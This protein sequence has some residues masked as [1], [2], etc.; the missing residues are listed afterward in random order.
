MSSEGVWDLIFVARIDGTPPEQFSYRPRSDFVFFLNRCPLLIIEICSDPGNE[1]DRH[2]MLLQAGL[3]ARVMNSKT[4]APFIVMAVYISHPFSAD[5]Y[6]V[7]LA[8]KETQEVITDVL[9]VNLFSSNF[10]RRL[11]M[12]RI[13]SILTIP[14]RHSSSFSNSITSPS[15]YPPDNKF[16]KA[17]ARLLELKNEVQRAALEGLTSKKSETNKSKPKGPNTEPGD[18]TSNC[19]HNSSIAGQLS[20]AGYRVPVGGSTLLRPVRSFLI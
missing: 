17:T 4:E 19:F 16:S 9:I 7:Y 18:N 15:H 1:S 20:S 6:L 13:H 12:S 5:R 14:A 11:D 8:D 2:R 10:I 3:L